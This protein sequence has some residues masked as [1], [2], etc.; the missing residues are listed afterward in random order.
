MKLFDIGPKIR[1][2][3]KEAGITQQSLA[4]LAG[5]SRITLG[6][7]ERG[8][9]ATVSIKTVD[10]VLNALGYELDINLHGSIPAYCSTGSRSELHCT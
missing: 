7:L 6:K 2:L 4:K 5:I 9:I 3:R 1:S 10:I 8:E